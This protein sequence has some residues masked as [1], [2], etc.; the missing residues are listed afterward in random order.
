MA[1]SETGAEETAFRGIL[2]AV[3][4]AHGFDGAS[5]KTTYLK[6]RVAIRMRA[7]GT[8]RYD[9]YLRALRGDPS[10]MK[11]LVDR[12]TVHVTEF[13]RDAEV[14]A[15]VEEKILPGMEEQFGGEVWRAWS[16]GCSTG[17]EAYS[18][19]MILKEWR[20]PR[21]NGDFLVE[22]TDI[23]PVSVGTAEKGDYPCDAVAKL[24]PARGERWFQKAGR[25]VEVV[26]AIRRQVRFGVRDLTG[27]WD[28]DW[29][30]F[31]LVFCRNLLIYL[32]PTEHQALYQRFAEILRPGGFLV[33]GRT[34]ALLGQGRQYF[35]CVDT[36]NRL[37][38][39]VE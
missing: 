4:A 11:R 2:E 3:R 30:P 38:R 10:E 35:Q 8:T 37:Y 9:E 29:G 27:D 13:F 20:E 19:A 33:L 1:M 14:Y 6:R 22:A 28:R 18:L 7:V 26:N 16:A 31:H 36:K 25:R 15:A 23:D 24:P 39:R 32:T 17:E 34:E 5:Y 21:G 12:L